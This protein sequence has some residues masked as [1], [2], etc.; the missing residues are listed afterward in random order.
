MRNPLDEREK[1]MIR[2]GVSRFGHA[3]GRALARSAG[4]E[5]PEI[6]WRLCEGPLFNN[7]VATLKVSGRESCVRLDKTI[8][9]EGDEFRLERVFDHPLTA[10]WRDDEEDS[11]ELPA[12]VRRPATKSVA[13]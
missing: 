9:P 4:V 11:A 10:G 7:Q 13:G 3:L 12:G 8:P 5:D 2:V 1:R 6:R